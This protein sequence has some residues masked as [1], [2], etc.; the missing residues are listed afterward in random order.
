M[1]RGAW[2]IHRSRKKKKSAGLVVVSTRY[3]EYR[4]LYGMYSIY[5][6]IL[7]SLEHWYQVHSV[8]GTVELSWSMGDGCV[9]ENVRANLSVENLCVCNAPNPYLSVSSS[10]G[11]N[12][13]LP[14][15]TTIANLNPWSW[16][17][18]LEIEKSKKFLI[19]FALLPLCCLVIVSGR[20]PTWGDLGCLCKLKI[21]IHRNSQ[22]EKSS[23][24]KQI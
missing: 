20:Q 1:S 17:T 3:A 6:Y 10:V 8:Q 22:L 14:S 16:N 23:C 5:W 9:T 4:I 11:W 13:F 7:Q 21:K 12:S 24:T 2:Y 19:N 15:F 18:K